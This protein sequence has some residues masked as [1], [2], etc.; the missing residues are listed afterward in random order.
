MLG[1]DALPYS[2]S[3]LERRPAPLLLTDSSHETRPKRVQS[4]VRESTAQTELKACSTARE[5]LYLCF[6][7]KDDSVK[8]ANSTV[9]MDCTGESS[10]YNSRS[11]P[12]GETSPGIGSSSALSRGL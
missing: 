5:A 3:I 9:T 6:T 8:V 7:L 10:I 11:C 2:A 4:Y 12:I 1:S